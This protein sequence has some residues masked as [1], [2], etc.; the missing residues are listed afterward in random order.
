MYD[1]LMAKTLEV[2]IIQERHEGTLVKRENGSFELEERNG[3]EPTPWEEPNMQ[4][5]ATF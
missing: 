5:A 4:G 2:N 1:F 3:S